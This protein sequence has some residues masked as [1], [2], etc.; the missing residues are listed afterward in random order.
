[1]A[2]SAA[3]SVRIPVAVAAVD[4]GNMASGAVYTAVMVDPDPD[5]DTVCKVL[6]RSTAWKTGGKN[7]SG[8]YEHVSKQG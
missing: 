4:L 1:M 3:A 5:P 8:G 2:R 6:N 7:G